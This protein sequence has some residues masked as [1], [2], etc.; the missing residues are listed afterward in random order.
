MKEH[1]DTTFIAEFIKDLRQ[2]NNNDSF[3]KV[4]KKLGN[5]GYLHHTM[6]FLRKKTRELL[7]QDMDRVK[8]L[9]PEHD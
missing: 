3:N 9:L 2:F 4:R 7:K 5:T 6:D 1:D 8:R